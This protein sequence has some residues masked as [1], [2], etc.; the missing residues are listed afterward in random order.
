MSTAANYVLR[1]ASVVLALYGLAVAQSL[2]A[3]TVFPAEPIGVRAPAGA[4]PV[5]TDARIGYTA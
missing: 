4:M 1:L 2:V 3:L 5:P